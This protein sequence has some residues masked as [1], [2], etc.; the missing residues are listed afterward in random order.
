MKRHFLIVSALFALTA[1]TELPHVRNALF[2]PDRPVECGDILAFYQQLAETK[3]SALNQIKSD[4]QQAIDQ[5]E[6]GCPTLKLAMLLSMPGTPLQNTAEAR[7]LLDRYIRKELYSNQ[8]ERR[9]ARLMLDH[10]QQ[11]ERLLAK[12]RELKSQLALEKERTQVLQEST[13]QIQIKLEQ[14]KNIEQEMSRKEQ[15]MATPS[16]EGI[17]NEPK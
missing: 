14:L 9:F 7:A 10:L 15:S 12:T 11:R 8:D 6:G 17:N 4:L 5:T 13:D 1:C 3:P 16:T 2:S